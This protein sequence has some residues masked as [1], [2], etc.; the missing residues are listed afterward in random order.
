[1]SRSF[2]V[3]LWD[4]VKIV[5]DR[6]EEGKRTMNDFMKFITD[7]L[8]AETSFGKDLQKAAQKAGVLSE[9]GTVSEA[10]NSLRASH[11]QLHRQHSEFAN[12][13]KREVITPIDTIKKDQS[14]QKDNLEKT[15]SR[16]TKDLE[17][18]KDNLKKSKVKYHDLS[19]Q[20]E[21]AL[22]MYEKAQQ[23][24]T[25]QSAKLTK[26]NTSQQQLKKETETADSQYRT[27]IKEFN[28]AQQKYEEGIKGVL[29]EFQEMDEKRIVTLKESYKKYIFYSETLLSGLEQNK[30]MLIKV[31]DNIDAFSDIQAFIEEKKTN[32]NP[33]TPIEYEPYVPT[34]GISA[35]TEFTVSSPTNFGKTGG[36]GKSSTIVPV[37]KNPE[38]L[39]TTSGSTI[40]KKRPGSTDAMAAVILGSNNAHKPRFK[41]KAMY[42]YTA[43]EA[44]E[45]SISPGDIIVVTHVDES[46]WWG[47]ELKGK[48]GQFPRNY[49][50]IHEGSE[51]EFKNAQAAAHPLKRC[52]VLFEF[53][54]SSPDELTV[55]VDEII[56]I[57]TETEGWFIGRND[58]GQS[59][60]FP[61]NYVTLLK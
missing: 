29:V 56:T 27:A 35:P 34:S 7:R 36:F 50:E 15:V 21:Q 37:V 52:K 1:M 5:Y 58:K 4:G 46:G 13:L 59:G 33:P 40:D 14:K 41:V 38:P 12:Q 24:P 51:E 39:K 9:R 30:I 55:K 42:D 10:Y 57:E 16:V 54:S 22:V 32:L 53:E 31:F 25:T 61:A 47:G 18:A 28:S 48:S 2:Q 6:Y 49:V 44:S 3:D 26:L 19:K 45:L 23:D 20:S 11:E 8:D 17:K 60:M 43:D